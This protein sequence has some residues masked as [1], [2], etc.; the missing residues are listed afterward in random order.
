[1]NSGRGGIELA[2]FGPEHYSE[3]Y[4]GWLNDAEVMRYTEARFHRH[5][6]DNALAYLEDARRDPHCRLFRILFDGEWHVGNVR[7]SGITLEHKRADIALIIGEKDIWGRGVATAAIR[8][9][10]AYG[11]E[12]L[13]LHKVTAGIYGDNIACIR[14]F[15][16]AGLVIEARRPEHYLSEDGFVD[17]VCMGMFVRDFPRP[18]RPEG[19][20]LI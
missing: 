13:G 1:M 19:G 9:A 10:S 5:T 14:A 20:S 17:R 16:K 11:F 12:E 18:G 7:I 6:R 3:A 8:L 4:L 15:E 2:P